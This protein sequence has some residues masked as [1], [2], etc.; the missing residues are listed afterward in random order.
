[1]RAQALERRRRARA[2]G[3]P[4]GDRA[5]LTR[6]RP[7]WTGSPTITSPSSATA[8]TTARPRTARRA[9]LDAV[10]DTGL[11]ILRQTAQPSEPRELQRRSRRPCATRP[12]AA[13]AHP[14]QGEPRADR[15]P[16][17]ATS[18]TS[19]SSVRRRRQ[20]DRRA[21]LPR[22]LH[23]HRLPREPA[24]DP[25]PAPQGRARARARRLPARQPRRARRC[26]RSS[27]RYPRDELFQI[28]DDELFEIAMGI[29]HLGERQRLR[30]FVRRDPFGRFFSCLV[31]VPRDRFNTE[32]RAR[33][34]AILRARFTGRA[35][36]LHARASPSRCSC[37]LHYLVY[38]D[39]AR[40]PAL[41][42]AGEIETLLVAAT[43]SW[44]DDLEAALIEEHGEERGG[45]LFRRYGDAFPPAYRADWV[46]RSARRRHRPASR[47]CRGRTAS[48][49]ASTARSRRRRS[50]A[51]QA[52]PRRPAAA[53]C[54]DML[55]LFENMGVRGRRRAALPDHAARPRAASGSTTSAST[56][57]GA[58]DA[59]HRRCARDASRTPSSRVWRGEVEN[60]GY[61]RL[62]LRR[63]A[64]PGARSRCCARSRS[65]LRQAGT[66]FSDTY[67]EQTLA[68]HPE[69]ARAA[70]A[71]CSRRA[72]TRR[73]ARRRADGAGLA[74]RDRGERSTRSRASTRTASCAASCASSRRCCAPTSSSADADGAPKPYLS[75]KLDPPA[76]SDWLPAAAPALR[77]LR[78]LAAHRGR[79][80]ARR[81]GRARRPALV[82]PPRGLPHRGARPDEGADGE[83]RG[84][85]AGR[86]RR[87][88][89]C[90]KR[91]P[92]GDRDAL[93]GGGDRLLPDLHPRPARPHRQPRR[94]R[95]RAAAGR[96]ALRRRRPVPRGR[97]RQGHG[98]VLRHRQRRSPPSTASGSATRS[99]PA[100]RPATTTR[101]WASPRAAPGSP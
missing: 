41:D 3:A 38:T 65:Y 50:A 15:P 30:L 93:L 52:L 37:A 18:T 6:P 45:A 57:A 74:E 66:T 77:D 82:G 26:S 76:I 8:S 92:R 100:A 1:M 67:I 99:P 69:I 19:A 49:C 44:A 87:A 97:R 89:S 7:S 46:A 78:L 63:R 5:R 48:R 40:A 101:R 98:D 36:R 4:P 84:D 59:R 21:P 11:G 31:F 39:P 51:R 42:D 17:R 23:V 14:D 24:R 85:R 28:A 88:A 86:A 13:P 27:R 25:D 12:R 54:R 91:P 55:P 22:P 16:R 72:S 62:V 32:N 68:A 64:R 90:V 47:S 61:N 34:E 33:I 83:E 81:Q 70:R 53:R 9:A 79:P 75:F 94:R 80:P 96:G 73:S 29:L 35:R 58:G 60:D 10:P 20:G 56:Y 2:A 71:R 43:R 95:D